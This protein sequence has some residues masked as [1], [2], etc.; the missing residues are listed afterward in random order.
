MELNSSAAGELA[1]KSPV[2]AP[3]PAMATVPLRE[4][5]SP[6]LVRPMEMELVPVPAVCGK[7][8]VAVLVNEAAPPKT[9]LMPGGYW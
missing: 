5:T 4:S 8:P 3:L 7:M 2:P 6:S 9:L 1:V